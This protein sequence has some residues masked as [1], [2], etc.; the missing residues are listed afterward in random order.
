MKADPKMKTDPKVEAVAVTAPP[1][2]GSKK[3]LMIMIGAL[4]IAIGGGGGIAWHFI[5]PSKNAHK[6][7]KIE[8]PVFVQLDPF[9][10]NLQ[11][12]SGEQFLQVSL[13]LQVENMTQIDIIKQNMPQ[14]RSRLVVL[15]SSKKASEIASTQGKTNLTNEIIAQINKPFAPT[16]PPQK[17][18]GVFFTSFIIQ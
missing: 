4:V 12:E 16:A 1:S 8:T 2:K 9:T 13:T 5:H 14:V 3:K 17:V 18:L 10:V 6:E 15:L 7:V 11:Q